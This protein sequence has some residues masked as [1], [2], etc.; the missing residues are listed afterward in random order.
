MEVLFLDEKKAVLFLDG[1]KAVLFLNG[2]K[3]ARYS[4]EL[5]RKVGGGWCLVE[6]EKD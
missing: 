4:N 5:R 2:K 1:K 6:R 3:A